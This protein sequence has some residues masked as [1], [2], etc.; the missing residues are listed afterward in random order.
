MLQSTVPNGKSQ[1]NSPQI[2]KIQITKTT[3]LMDI[4]MCQVVHY[5]FSLLHSKSR[6]EPT[7]IR[8]TQQTRNI[9]HN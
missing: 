6:I 3:K 2:L 5:P 1:I 8:R 4:N 7:K 9:F